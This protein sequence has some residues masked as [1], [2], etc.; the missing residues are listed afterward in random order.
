MTRSLATIL[1]AGVAATTPPAQF[2]SRVDGVRVDVL[3]TDRGRAVTGLQAS[4]FEVRDNGALQEVRLV[5]AGDVPVSTVLTLDASASLAPPRLA[6]LK[7]AGVALLDRLVPGDAAALVTF[8]TLVIRAVAMTTDLAAVRQAVSDVSTIAETS[9]VDAAVAA[10]LVGESDAGR[11]L[12]VV[13]SDGVDTTSFLSAPSALATARRA[14]SVVYGVWS[15][16]GRSG[17]LRQLADATG[18]RVGEIGDDDPGPAFVEILQEFRQRYVVTFVPEAPSAGWHALDVR[19]KR[20][21]VKVQTRSGYFGA[22]AIP[23]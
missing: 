16:G 12:V 7:R 18:G 10:L 22:G 2:T 1:L 23:R 11:T 19:V 8:N 21:G 15:G 14:N 20:P 9:L 6:A 5:S 4:D 13:F 3:V 17:F